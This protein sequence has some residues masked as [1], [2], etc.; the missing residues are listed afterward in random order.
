MGR[1]GAKGQQF[2]RRLANEAFYSIRKFPSRNAAILVCAIANGDVFKRST[3]HDNR[4]E[5]VINEFRFCFSVAIFETPRVFVRNIQLSQ[6]K[7]GPD[8]WNY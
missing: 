8:V 4:V 2:F 6:L 7:R 1:R 3:D 5:K